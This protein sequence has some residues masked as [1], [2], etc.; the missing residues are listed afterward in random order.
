MRPATKA[1]RKLRYKPQPHPWA[2][3]MVEYYANGWHVGTLLHAIIGGDVIVRHP[4]K[5][6][7]AIA[8][9]NVRLPIV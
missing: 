3:M 1:K 5:G 9:N 2:G 7:C 6:E 8:A 4:I